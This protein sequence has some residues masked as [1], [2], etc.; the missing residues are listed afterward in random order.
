MQDK[1]ILQG[2]VNTFVEKQKF[3]ITVPV[4]WRPD[5][6]VA[7]AIRQSLL[8]R[9]LHGKAIQL[10]PEPLPD[11]RTFIINPCKVANMWRIAGAATELPDEIREGNLAEIVLPLIKDHLGTIVY[12]VAAGIQNN[13]EEPDPELITFIERNFDNEDLYSCLFPVL[14]NVGMQSFLNSIVLAKGTVNILKPKTSP[15]D[16]SE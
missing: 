10:P 12:I 15:T 6:P 5:V 3:T 4:S 7:P 2:V 13:H 14:E 8:D 16:G 9:L 11:E 1:N